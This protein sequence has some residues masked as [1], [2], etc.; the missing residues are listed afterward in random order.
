MIERSN[1]KMEKKRTGTRRRKITK[2]EEILV[3]LVGIEMVD[4][5]QT[6]TRKEGTQGGRRKGR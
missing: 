5:R 3:G 4:K 2:E 6:K 1:T